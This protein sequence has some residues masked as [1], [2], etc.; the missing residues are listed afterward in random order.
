MCEISIKTNNPE[1]YK[2]YLT[3]IRDACYVMEE[4]SAI[5]DFALSK[6]NEKMC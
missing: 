3:K 6:V 2:K 1:K 5:L 4:N